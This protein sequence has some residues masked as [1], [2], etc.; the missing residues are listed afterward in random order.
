MVN[1]K[2]ERRKRIFCLFNSFINISGGDQRFIEI[3]KRM[4]NFSKFIIT[5]LIG[6]EI[7]ERNK[8]R[9]TFFITTREPRVTNV[10]LTYFLRIMRVLSINLE[11]RENDI[12]YSTSDFLLDTFPAFIWKLQNKNAKWIVCIF[13]IVPSLFR[14]YSKS[15]V[16]NNSF[17]LP[18][19]GRILYFLSQ[20]LTMFLGK[21]WADKTLVLN[22]IDKKFLVD[23][24]GFAESLVRVVNGGVDYKHIQSLKANGKISYDAV[25]LGRFHPQ[26]GIFDL[27]KIWRLVCDKKPD[28]K[29]CI[30]GSGSSLFLEKVRNLVKKN[31]LLSNVE[32][33][34]L[35][36][37]DEKLLLLKSSR[38]FL[39]PSYYESFAIVIA[40][41]M[42]CGLPV[43]AYNLP[44]YEGI[45]GKNIVRV[46]LGNIHQ[47]ADAVI[48]FLDDNNLRK[49]FGLD[50][51]KF[52]DRYNWDKI[53]EEEY[54]LFI[55]DDG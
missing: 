48:T 35:K 49:T 22:N 34:G 40:E 46:Q 25:F 33:V 39:C 20:R 31:N 52:V 24:I 54:T 6:K 26:K 13:L 12:I 19:F 45:Y 9:A 10:I 29:L 11:I 30:I 5:P 27:I 53:V 14:D 4:N 47:F 41:A 3:F 42:A 32:L 8:V 2:R 38:L 15:Y 50:S 17:S 55:D 36:L 7:C 16:K 18:S 1:A 23:N 43:V 21:R 28:A 51:E 44:I 37:G